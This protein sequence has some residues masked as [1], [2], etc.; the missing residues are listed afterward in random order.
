MTHVAVL[1]AT[2]EP[3]AIVPL[4]R[5]MAFLLH[6]RAVIVEAV[7]GQTVRSAT[8]EFPMPR[9]VQFRE[10]VRVPYRHSVLPWTR[11]GLLAR[12]Q[13]SCAYCGRHANTIDHVQPRSRG[14]RNTWLNTVA[15]CHRCNNQKADRTPE[16]AD[17]PLRFPPREVTRRD[18]LVLGIGALGADMSALGLASAGAQLQAV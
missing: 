10:M 11:A 18:T 6:E 8:A 1:N 2:F 14:G 17:M 13:H 5:A 15:S 4:R 12:D 7:P 3:L 16:E 9:V